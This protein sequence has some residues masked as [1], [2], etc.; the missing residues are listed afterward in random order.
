MHSARACA[1]CDSVDTKYRVSHITKMKSSFQNTKNL[2]VF[3]KNSSFKRYP[4]KSGIVRTPKELG[5][6]AGRY[7]EKTIFAHILVTIQ[8]K[9]GKI[10]GKF[11]CS[12]IIVSIW[13][14]F[15]KEFLIEGVER[16]K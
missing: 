11:P 6:E 2:H 13:F 10:T 14:L 8:N 12:L 7:I 3:S 9:D 4:V 1:L 5:H 16:R 15:I